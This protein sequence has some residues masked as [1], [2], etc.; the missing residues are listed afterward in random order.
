MEMDCNLVP[1]Y[2]GKDGLKIITV[3]SSLEK[4][5]YMLIPGHERVVSC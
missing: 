4:S 1:V 2:F 3:S 5:F